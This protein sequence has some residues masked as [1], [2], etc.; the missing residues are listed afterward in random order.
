M[1]TR[2]MSGW[3]KHLDFLIFDAIM[4]ELAL[5]ISYGIRHNWSYQGFSNIYQTLTLLLAMSSVC[6][7]ILRESYHGILRRDAFRECRETFSHVTMVEIILIAAA[8]FLK[9]FSYSR[10]VFLL[11]WGIGIVFCFT[12][13][14]LWRRVL[15]KIGI[16]KRKRRQVLLITTSELA[17]KLAKEWK[18]QD[19]FDCELCG[20]CLVDRDDEGYGKLD[21]IDGIPVTGRITEIREYLLKYVVDEVLI[22]PGAILSGD[23][24]DELLQAGLT[25]HISVEDLTQSSVP[26]CLETFAGSVVL[27]SAIRIVRPWEMWAKRLMDIAGSLVGLVITGI[28]CIFVIPAIKMAD[29]GPAFFTQV[30]IGKNGRRFRIYKFRSMYQDAED[31]K[32]ELMARNEMKG[33][34]FKMKDDPRI[35]K[36]IGNFIR[37]TSIDELPQFWNVLKGDMSLVGTR[38]PTEEEY[39]SYEMRYMRRLAIRPGITGIWQ[40]SGRN[41]IKDFDDVVRMDT[42]YINRWSLML[43]IRLLCKTVKVVLEGDGAA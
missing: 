11:L 20:I 43:D 26:T 19:I 13:R 10:E 37:K 14:C 27:T 17:E 6:V 7:G 28:A 5:F 25:V 3:G 40:T 2:S 35:I 8:F 36:G 22:R 1:Y 39:N 18:L 32:K 41:S 33:A 24:M 29:P 38:P 30:R 12:E 21:K 15:K 34:M 42:E 31:R 23:Q 16:G 4:L 9:E